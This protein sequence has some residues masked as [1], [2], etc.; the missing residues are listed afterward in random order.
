VGPLSER[1][2]QVLSK[3]FSS[4]GRN[5]TLEE[6]GKELG[7]LSKERVRQ[8]E[9]RALAKLVNTFLNNIEKGHRPHE[10][11]RQGDSLNHTR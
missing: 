8:I 3:R 11:F 2:I 4:C 9:E 7:N 5:K 10:S 6:V 1:E